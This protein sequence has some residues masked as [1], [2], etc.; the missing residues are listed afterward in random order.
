MPTQVGSGGALSVATDNA[1]VYWIVSAGGAI[2][3]A[4][5]GGG[6]PSTILPSSSGVALTIGGTYAYWFDYGASPGIMRVLLTGGT[7]GE[8]FA[9]QQAV[10][11]GSNSM[12]VAMGNLY[13]ASPSAVMKVSLS[14]GA[15]TPLASGLGNVTSIALDGTDIYWTD[16]ARG[17]VMR[18]PLGG[19]PSETLASG[20]NH[21]KTIVVDGANAYWT[22]Q[23]VSNSDGAVMELTK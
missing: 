20:Q 2:Q 4:A 23:G 15:P 7:T 11:G 5:L 16:F 8:T 6:A 13:W 18:A 3:S 14:G 19:G 9:P 17:T 21:P 1:N 12:R 22:N 10:S